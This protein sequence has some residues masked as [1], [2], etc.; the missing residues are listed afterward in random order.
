MLLSLLQLSAAVASISPR[1]VGCRFGVADITTARAQLERKA[2]REGCG[3][4]R[5]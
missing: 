4:R 1:N 5:A 2:R 3:E